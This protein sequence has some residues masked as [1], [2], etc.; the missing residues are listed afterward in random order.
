MKTKFYLLTL[1]IMMFSGNEV[2]AQT[3]Q[4]EK[5]VLTA[6]F[7]HSG[8]TKTVANQ[9]KEITG[10]DLFEIVPATAYPTEY[11]AVVAQAKKEINASYKPELKE[12]PKSLDNYDVLI[13]GSPCW[14]GTIAPP[15]AAF[16]SKYDLSGK[17]I[18]PFMTHEGSRMGH[19]IPDIKKLCPKSTVTEGLPIRGSNVKEAKANV[20]KWLREN[21][22]AR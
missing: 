18:M 7:S 17:T 11:D 10:S 14:W 1:M 21:K 6:Y 4:K 20:V 2:K 5:K 9:I 19:T 15:V 22:L 16:L 12:F 8:N 3:L 13:I